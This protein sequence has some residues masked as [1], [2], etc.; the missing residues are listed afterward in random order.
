M[1]MIGDLRVCKAFDVVQPND[2]AGNR[3]EPEKCPLQIR[4]QWIGMSAAGFPLQ[5]RDSVVAQPGQA[6]VPRRAQIHESLVHCNA[7]YPSDEGAG[8]SI[9]GHAAQDFDKYIL[10][11][12]LSEGRADDQPAK[13]G[14]DRL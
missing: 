5:G 10:E 2:G 12:I 1:E 8:A 14:I 9:T 6:A 11:Q 7:L 13:Q 4:I 3:G